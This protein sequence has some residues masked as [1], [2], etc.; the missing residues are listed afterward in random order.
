[1]RTPLI[2]AVVVV[3]VLGLIF[4]LSNPPGRSRPSFEP[5]QVGML[6]RTI[7]ADNV[8]AIEG[9]RKCLAADDDEG[10][11]ELVSRKSAEFVREGT[12]CLVIKQMDNWVEV[13]IDPRTAKSRVLLVPASSVMPSSYDEIE[14]AKK[15]RMNSPPDEPNGV[16]KDAVFFTK[17]SVIADDMLDSIA[18]KLRSFDRA[19]EMLV[20]V[21]SR[22]EKRKSFVTEI[23][24]MK[25]VKAGTEITFHEA[26][27][28]DRALISISRELGV[29]QIQWDAFRSKPRSKRVYPFDTSRFIF[30]SE[31]MVIHFDG[32][33]ATSS[34]WKVAIDEAFKSDDIRFKLMNEGKIVEVE[35]ET[36]CIVETINDAGLVQVKLESGEHK[37]KTVYIMSDQLRFQSNGK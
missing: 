2:V 3:C 7:A 21:S 15:D 35:K 9:I 29:Y 37:G 12:P 16:E 17:S 33:A 23:R 1:V 32:V 30:P 11:F 14:T 25:L 34:V 10:L 8:L 31:K 5:G 22:I 20:Q 4:F 19:F 26:R 13:R 18:D 24:E 28:D 27:T 6:K 36:A